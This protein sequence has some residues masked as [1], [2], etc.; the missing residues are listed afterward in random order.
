M[1]KFPREQRGLKV[2]VM[3]VLLFSDLALETES[4]H[5]DLDASPETPRCGSAWT[6]HKLLLS[7]RL[8]R[9]LRELCFSVYISDSML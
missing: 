6:P 4:T 7:D 5:I 1:T 3:L 2:D 9:L 8:S